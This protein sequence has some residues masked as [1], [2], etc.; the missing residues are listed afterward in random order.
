M[1]ALRKF[2]ENALNEKQIELGSRNILGECEKKRSDAEPL[3][4]SDHCSGLECLG[5]GLMSKVSTVKALVL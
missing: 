4:R 3:M 1:P 5:G 2:G